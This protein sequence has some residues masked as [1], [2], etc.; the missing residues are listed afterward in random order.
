MTEWTEWHEYHKDKI[1]IIPGVDCWIWVGGRTSGKTHGR[2]RFTNSSGE[3]YSEYSHRAAFISKNG[4]IEKGKIVCHKCGQGLCVRPSHLYAG[5]HADNG[6]DTV[7]MG[8][9]TA[10]LTYEQAYEVRLMYQRGMSLQKIADKFGIAFG[11]VYPIVMGRAY[12]HVPMPK[13][14]TFGRRF[15]APLSQEE[16]ADIRQMLADGF[17]QRQI[18]E[19]HRIAASIVSRINTGQRHKNR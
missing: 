5:T 13:N 15:R 2:V 18:S 3:R 11:S 1:E 6:K 7:D 12:K 4:F 9:G 17:T 14:Y 19:K 16:L 10:L 8:M